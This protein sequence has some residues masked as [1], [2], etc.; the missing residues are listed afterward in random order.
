M[1]IIKELSIN[2][3]IADVWEVLGNQFGAIDQ[4]ASLISKSE[5]SGE[6]K[7][8]GVSFTF[9]STET[10]KGPT[11][12]ELT[13]WNPEQHALS[14]KAIA[15]TPGFFKSVTASWS[16]TLMDQSTTKL[17]LDFEVKFKGIAA[18]LTPLVKMKLG[19][20]GDTLLDDFKYYVE[21]GKPHPR[22]VAAK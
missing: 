2:K 8:P 12:Q 22:K 10:E 6:P 9:R 17:T 16:L 18:I 20:I 21:N 7:F 13:S 4:W 15:G 3:P 14:Y 19:K 11:K 5:V 1:K